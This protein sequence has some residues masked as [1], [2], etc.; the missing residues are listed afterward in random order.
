VY[1]Y[2]N[3]AALDDLTGQISAHAD[4]W[5][6]CFGMSDEE[7]TQQIRADGIDIL[8]GHFGHTAGNRL[9]TLARRLSPVQMTW[10]GYPATTG[11]SSMDYRITSADMDP[12]G[13]TER[14]HTET[15]IR[16]PA[17][18][19]FTPSGESPPVNELPA[20]KSTSFTFACLNNLAKINPGVV[21]VWGRILAKCPNAKLILGNVVDEGAR[22]HLIGLFSENDVSTAQLIFSPRISLKDFLALHSQIDLA[23]DPFPFNGGTT[24]LHALWMGVPV[25]TLCGESPASRCGAAVLRFAGLPE[26]IAG[27]EQEYVEIA[28]AHA[29]NLPKLNQIRRGLRDRM[30]SRP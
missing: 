3:N 11:L 22:R 5:A 15:L 17:S 30:T 29:A 13:V 25:V 18:A 4:H 14:F 9:P 26:F 1:C 28:L 12:P 21:A 8:V 20:L 27:T 7:L 6:P 10:V 2:Y 23:L 24:S 16:L 19:A